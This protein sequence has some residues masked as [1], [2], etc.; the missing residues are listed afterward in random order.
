MH[1]VIWQA[2]SRLIHDS[3]RSKYENIPIGDNVMQSTDSDE[4]PYEIFIGT[5][6]GFKV[7]LILTILSLFIFILF[8]QLLPLLFLFHTSYAELLYGTC[9]YHLLFYFSLFI[10]SLCFFPLLYSLLF[11]STIF[12]LLFLSHVILSSNS[13]FCRSLLHFCLQLQLQLPLHLNFSHDL[14]NS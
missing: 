11:F 13:P 10:F 6:Y 5:N 1:E 9:F 3:A 7:Q 8:L 14:H 4:K 2:S 12:S